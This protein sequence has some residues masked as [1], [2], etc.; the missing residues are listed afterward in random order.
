MSVNGNMSSVASLAVNAGG[1]LGGNGTVGNTT[2]KAAAHWRPAIRSARSTRQRQPGAS[3]AA[4]TYLVE[5]SSGDADR[6]N[7]TGTA[8]L[9]GATVQGDLCQRQLTSRSNTRSSTPAV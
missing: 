5:V 1:T 7:V 9:G 8:T 6:I 2:I 3:R 4:S